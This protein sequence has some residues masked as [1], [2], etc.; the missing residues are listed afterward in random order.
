MFETAGRCY[1]VVVSVV[2]YWASQG[3]VDIGN[4]SINISREIQNVIRRLHTSELVSFGLTSLGSFW[5]LW[6]FGCFRVA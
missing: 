6:G 1:K 2:I 4:S 3:G 5:S